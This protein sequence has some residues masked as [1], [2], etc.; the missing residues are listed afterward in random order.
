MLVTECVLLSLPYLP[1]LPPAG[2][3]DSLVF[4][5]WISGN[6]LL[7]RKYRGE[8]HPIATHIFVCK[9]LKKK[10]YLIKTWS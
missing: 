2:R 1:R 5:I 6:F 3:Q 8:T 9:R 10:L 4:G 7:V